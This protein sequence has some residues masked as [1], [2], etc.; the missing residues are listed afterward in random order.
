MSSQSDCRRFRAVSDDKR[1]IDLDRD[2]MNAAGKH[3]EVYAERYHLTTRLK[4]GAT[5]SVTLTT[6]TRGNKGDFHQVSAKDVVSFDL[7]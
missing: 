4:Y 1:E 6:A 7:A 5:S 3:G 2:A